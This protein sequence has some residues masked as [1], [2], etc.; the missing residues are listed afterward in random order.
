MKAHEGVTL[1]QRGGYCLAMPLVS[2]GGD[3]I[4]RFRF[5]L[6]LSQS[7][8]QLSVVTVCVHQR[9]TCVF[10]ETGDFANENDVI[11]SCKP[12]RTSAA[13]N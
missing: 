2:A 8:V 12:L 11:A 5:G 1:A 10:L 3:Q 7:V 9:S 13:N 4:L 6:V